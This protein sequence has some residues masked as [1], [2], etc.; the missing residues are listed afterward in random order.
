MPRLL[1]DEVLLAYWAAICRNRRSRVD[2]GLRSLIVGPSR[3]RWERERRADDL[4]DSM[5]LSIG[6]DRPVP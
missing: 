5:A 4:T 2:H 3:G 6:G 1:I